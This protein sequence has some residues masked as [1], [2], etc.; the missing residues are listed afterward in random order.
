MIAVLLC[1]GYAT[2]L[3][4]LTRNFPKPLLPVAGKPVI[5]YLVDQILGLPEIECLHI[6]TN[7]KFY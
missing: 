7:D 2:R 6:V 1:A 3:Y 4:P 5:E